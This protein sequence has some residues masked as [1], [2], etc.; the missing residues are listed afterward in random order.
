MRRT[1]FQS[2]LISLVCIILVSCEKGEDK[3]AVDTARTSRT[4]FGKPSNL[5]TT[6]VDWVYTT[7]FACTYTEDMFSVDQLKFHANQLGTGY[8]Y[9]FPSSMYYEVLSSYGM[10]RQGTR[11]ARYHPQDWAVINLQQEMQQNSPQ[12]PIGSKP[13]GVFNGK[14]LLRAISEAGFQIVHFLGGE[15]REP[16]DVIMYLCEVGRQ[17]NKSFFRYAWTVNDSPVSK[18]VIGV[19]NT[20]RSSNATL[21]SGNVFQRVTFKPFYDTEGRPKGFELQGK[22][23]NGAPGSAIYYLLEAEK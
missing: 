16:Y 9:L 12:T 4:G 21:I 6:N 22:L 5:P 11:L 20:M 7:G 19:D 14:Y 13:S 17:G 18:G 8:G 2:C 3:S 10:A 23:A 15:R 1:I